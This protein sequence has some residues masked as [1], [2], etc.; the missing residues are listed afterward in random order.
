[1][2]LLDVYTYSNFAQALNWSFVSK[3]QAKNLAAIFNV[4]QFG[5]KKALLGT[6]LKPSTVLMTAYTVITWKLAQA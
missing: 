6:E 2:V 1:M 4:I 5:D 3:F